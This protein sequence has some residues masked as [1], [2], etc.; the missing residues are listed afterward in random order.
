M[1]HDDKGAAPEGVEVV[2]L[3][4]TAGGRALPPET[5][6][7]SLANVAAMFGVSQLKLRYYE[8]RGLIRRRHT[9]G[10]VRVYGWA[11]C[12]RIAVVIKCRRAGLPLR[13]LV[14]VVRATDTD[15]VATET[16]LTGR[17]SCMALVDRLEQHRRAIDEA[18]AELGHVHAL[19]ATKNLGHGD[20]PRRG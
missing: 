14:R 20:G 9:H 16:F 12:E 10:R 11:D 2:W 13:D 6:V 18:L 4:D 5:T 8:L 1:S 7:L 3:D 17:Q 19:L 15:D